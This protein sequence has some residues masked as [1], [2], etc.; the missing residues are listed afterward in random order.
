MNNKGQVVMF[1]I[2]ITAMIIIFSIFLID[3]LTDILTDVRNGSQLDCDNTSIS[4]GR[5]IT[6]LQVDLILPYF[7]GSMIFIGVAFAIS[8]SRKNQI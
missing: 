1:G 5:Q 4:T 8:M 2:L 3:P 6:C 7:I